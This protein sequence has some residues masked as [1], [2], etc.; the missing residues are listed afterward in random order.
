MGSVTRFYALLKGRGVQ[1]R[2]M[3]RYERASIST[4]HVPC[5]AS[6]VLWY[7]FT[8]TPNDS[9]PIGADRGQVVGDDLP[10]VVP[11]ME[12]AVDAEL[13]TITHDG[14]RENVGNRSRVL[15]GNTGSWVA[16]S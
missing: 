4:K 2:L 16:Q 1:P 13:H 14:L 6:H 3:R 5:R 7:F 8:S 15:A 12:V 9:P 11:G 10:R